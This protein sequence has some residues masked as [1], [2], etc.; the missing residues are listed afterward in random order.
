MKTPD[1]ITYRFDW[2]ATRGLGTLG[3]GE[4]TTP[5]DRVRV[6][7]LATRVEDRYGN[8]VEYTYDGNGYPLFIRGYATGSSVI[9]REIVLTYTGSGLDYR[10][11]TATAHGRTWNYEYQ[12]GAIHQPA[13]DERAA[14]NEFG[15][16]SNGASALELHL[17]Q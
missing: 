16:R 7:L 6:Y 2:M 15:H 10:L 12:S 17:L 8:R 3:S 4:G 5:Q 14:A 13:I 9:E 11:E 1:G